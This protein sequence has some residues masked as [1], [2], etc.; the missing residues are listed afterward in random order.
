MKETWGKLQIRATLVFLLNL[1]CH[2]S[3][4]S[5]LHFSCFSTFLR[6]IFCV[7]GSLSHFPFF[8]AS[9]SLFS[10]TIHINISLDPWLLGE[11]SPFCL[12]QGLLSSNPLFP[13]S[14]C[15]VVSPGLCFPNFPV[16]TSKFVGIQPMA[17]R[18]DSLIWTCFLF[19]YFS[20]LVGIDCPLKGL[21]SFTQL[22]PGSPR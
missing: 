2:R 4:S 3:H 21:K 10:V 8:F 7:P 1:T 12:I 20:T 6:L 16:L 11:Q 18:T 5:S 22:S 15:Q 17:K 9:L 14:K 19:S 13:P